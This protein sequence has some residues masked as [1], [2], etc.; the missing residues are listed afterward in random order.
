MPLFVCLHY[1]SHCDGWPPALH[2]LRCMMGPRRSGAIRSSQC[3]LHALAAGLSRLRCHQSAAAA[4]I[5]SPFQRSR[6]IAWLRTRGDF[7]LW[8]HSTVR[9]CRC[10][11]L[12]EC[13]PSPF[14]RG[15]LIASTRANSCTATVSRLRTLF[16]RHGGCRWIQGEASD[17]ARVASQTTTAAVDT[18]GAAASGDQRADILLL[19][20]R[21]ALLRR[22]VRHCL[23]PISAALL[24]HSRVA[25]LH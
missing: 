11:V 9:C 8:C 15:D 19:Q 12:S 10:G 21:Y 13:S 22:R 5:S 25:V 4:P 18:H 23:A 7:R 20:T 1:E 17:C 24:G 2:P 6:R 16:R 3:G 14:S